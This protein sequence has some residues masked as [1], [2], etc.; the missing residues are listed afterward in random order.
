MTAK[1]AR[2]SSAFVLGLLAMAFV[3]ATDVSG[4]AGQPETKK[5]AAQGNTE[6]QAE[7]QVPE[8]QITEKQEPTL[9]VVKWRPVRSNDMIKMAADRGCNYLIDHRR[10]DGAYGSYADDVGITALVVQALAQS[11]RAYRETDGPFITKAV[12][13]MLG[14]AKPDG[15]IYNAGQGLENYKT[16]VSILALIALDAGREKKRYADAVARAR[17]Y[18]MTLQADEKHGYDKTKH[19]AAF[20]GIGYGSD[21]R[22]DVSNTHFAIEALKA[23]GVSE[24]SEAFKR[25]LVFLKRCQNSSDNDYF[26]EE[27]KSKTTGDGGMFYAPGSTK[28]LVIKNEDGTESFSSYGSMT[29]AGLKSLVYAGLSKDHPLCKQAFAWIEKNYTVE[30]NPGMATPLHPARGWNGLYYYYMVMARTLEALEVRTV[31]TPDG[32]EHDW[33]AEL[34]GRLIALQAED[35]SWVNPIDRW[36]EGDPNVTTA[37]A[38]R[39]LSICNDVMSKK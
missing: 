23:A 39:A 15:G 2:T 25:A 10:E 7:K 36:W 13:Y 16:S 11:P 21:R 9:P 6:P 3:T 37:Y 17:E 28:T 33:A 27:T 30:V 24:D 5:P 32:V 14:K 19:K 29:Y 35:G 26:G 8:K 12:E 20:G 4:Q 22:P 18:V 38:V 34:A 1:F 31:T